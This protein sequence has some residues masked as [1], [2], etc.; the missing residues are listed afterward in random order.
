MY[1]FPS[2]HFFVFYAPVSYQKKANHVL[3]ALAVI[4]GPTNKRNIQRVPA[5][6]AI[7]ATNIGNEICL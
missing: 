2:P 4:V 5:P 6:I 3:G 7:A 1:V